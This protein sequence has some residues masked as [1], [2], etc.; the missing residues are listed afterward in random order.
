MGVP[1]HPGMVS[2]SLWIGL[3][4]RF[5]NLDKNK[6]KECCPKELQGSQHLGVVGILPHPGKQ[7]LTQ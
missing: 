6:N 2:L 3:L 7:I 4:T 1:K 5:I